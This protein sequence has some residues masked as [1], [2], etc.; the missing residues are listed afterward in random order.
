MGRGDYF[1]LGGWVSTLSTGGFQGSLALGGRVGLGCPPGIQSFRC[2]GSLLSFLPNMLPSMAILFS[3]RGMCVYTI[4]SH[5]L[6]QHAC[7]L[8]LLCG[9]SALAG[10]F[11]CLLGARLGLGYPPG[12]QSFLCRGLLLS[13]LPNMLPNMATYLLGRGM[14][15]YTMERRHASFDP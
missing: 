7:Y 12:A 5:R 11:H 1:F 14:C 3:G 13:F 8:G 15:V 6:H 2:L 10:G 9:V 4:R